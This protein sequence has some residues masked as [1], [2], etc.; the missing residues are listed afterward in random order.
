MEIFWVA[1]T[2]LFLIVFMFIGTHLRPLTQ[3]E[4]KQLGV[5]RRSNRIKQYFLFDRHQ[6]IPNPEFKRR[7]NPN[8]RFYQV[9]LPLYESPSV[10]AA[11]LKYKKHEWIIVALEKQKRIFLMWV[12]KGI[13][14]G[15]VSSLVAPETLANLARE[16]GATSVLIFHN[17]PN[18]A[19]D[20]LDCSKP[21]QLDLKSAETFTS[22]FH[23]FDL[24]LLE[25]IC[26]RGVHHEYWRRSS[27]A[28]LPLDTF[29]AEILKING[30]SR[31]KNLLLHI[32]RL[33]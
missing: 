15:S 33:F 18:P 26:E 24:N 13:D 30:L 9:D 19:P 27:N 16:N 21:S 1:C 12:N 7:M 14:R 20:A 2:V 4:I 31:W 6:Y 3:A 23:T 8:G 25:F 28:F 11:L 32:E 29:E 10:A 5:K 17:H 22:I